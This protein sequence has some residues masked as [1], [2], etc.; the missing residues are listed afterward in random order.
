M[1]I[2]G[3]VA[4][5][6]GADS[7][8]GA[9]VVRGLLARGVGKV[10]ADAHLDSCEIALSGAVPLFVAIGRQAR[11]AKLARDLTDVNLLVNCL[12]ARHDSASPSD[13]THPQARDPH[14]PSVGRIL[15]L[16]DAFA[17]VLSANGGGAVVNVLCMLHADHL[18]ECAPTT[19]SRPLA[20]WMLA[21]GTGERLAA[22]RTQLL[23]LSAQLVIGTGF[24]ARDDQGALAGHVAM[25]LLNQLEA[26]DH[27]L[28]VTL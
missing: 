25:R 26:G 9:S 13:G 5:V 11:A 1:K 10:Y 19:P 24:Q 7:A 18:S 2:A 14:T 6:I 27:G 16:I 3:A 4:L 21:A 28:A 15:K 20:E 8:V 17:P 12:V 23:F 22:Q